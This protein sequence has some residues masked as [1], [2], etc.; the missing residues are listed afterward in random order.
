MWGALVHP[1]KPVDENRDGKSSATKSS[2]GSERLDAYRPPQASD[3]SV[4]TIFDLVKPSL[5]LFMPGCNEEAWIRDLYSEA[6][7]KGVGYAEEAVWMAIRI[8]GRGV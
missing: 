6:F 3:L 7:E 8:V 1:R 5:A 4:P 2:R